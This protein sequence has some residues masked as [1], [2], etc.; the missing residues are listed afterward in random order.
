MIPT[1]VR[2]TQSAAATCNAERPTRLK[3]KAVMMVE[4]VLLGRAEAA[5]A[6]GVSLSLLDDLVADGLPSVQ[7]RGRR[8]FRPGD[9]RTFA[10]GL[11]TA[12][13]DRLKKK[14]ENADLDS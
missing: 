11:P 6:L 9:L 2:R 4:P 5:R 7:L 13:P 12:P 1:V 14:R 3:T 8:M 10:G